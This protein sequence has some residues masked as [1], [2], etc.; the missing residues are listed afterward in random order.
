MKITG[1]LPANSRARVSGYDVH[2]ITSYNEP[3]RHKRLAL[4]DLSNAIPTHDAFEQAAAAVKRIV[5]TPDFHAG[6]PVPVGVAM[7]IEGAAMPHVIGNDIGCGMRMVV[8]N[9]VTEDD[10]A[11][12]ALDGHL[13]HVHFQGGRNIALSGRQRHA[14]LR[15]GIPGLLEALAVDAKG[16]LDNLELTSAWN[17]V[18]RTCDDGFFPSSGIDSGFLDYGN[19]TDGYRYDA[20]LGSIGGGNHFV[21]L[22]V[23]DKIAD[24]TFAMTAGVKAGAVVM[25]VHSGSLDFGQYVGSTTKERMRGLA[26]HGDH[27]ILSAEHHAGE[28]Q[29]FLNGQANAVNIAFTNRFLIGLATIHAVEKSLGK[30]VDAKLVYDAPHNVIWSDGNTYMHR[31]GS[32]PARGQGF[33]HGSPYE[34]LGEPVILPGSMGDGT[35]LLR[36]LGNEETLQSAAHGAGRRLSR[37]EA[38]A[39]ANH[40]ADLR[41]I[42]PIDLNAPEVR[43][44]SDIVREIVGRLKEESPDA[45]RPIENVVAPME[46]TGMVN[47]VAKVR[48]VITVKG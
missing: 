42:T 32:C 46:D 29:R 45:Y 39:E 13:R 28:L 41:V 9:D 12:S 30:Q 38:R 16:L 23:I 22:G 44:R 26:R 21:E 47:K 24:S 10:L 6:K 40:P 8:L 37:Q 20:I 11:A 34:W 48:P 15:E 43:C 3:E 4:D 31:K 7:S 19:L 25:V 33:Q 2:T 14:I 27:R 35:W 36:G 18:S 1:I 5:T 17:D